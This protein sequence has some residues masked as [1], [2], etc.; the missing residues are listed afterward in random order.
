MS[1]MSWVGLGPGRFLVIQ[2]STAERRALRS[3]TESAWTSFFS[4]RSREVEA[5]GLVGTAP[6]M[7]AASNIILRTVFVFLRRL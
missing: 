5:T 7:T 4:G 3:S 2:A 1:G 6:S